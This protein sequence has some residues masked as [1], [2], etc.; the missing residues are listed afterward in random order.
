M[1]RIAFFEFL[2][3]QM[4]FFSR[5]F[6]YLDQ[7]LDRG[8]WRFHQESYALPTA[9]SQVPDMDHQ[10][11][12]LINDAEYGDKFYEYLVQ[13]A[14]IEH[15]LFWL[16]VSIFKYSPRIPKE[17]MRVY[18]ALVYIMQDAPLTISIAPE[19]RASIVLTL[20]GKLPIEPQMFDE[21]FFE[22]HWILKLHV[23]N[24]LKKHNLSEWTPKA[25]KFLL[26]F[27]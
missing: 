6:H 3:I 9:D 27:I 7:L 24:F 16:D 2:I 14:S 1:K 11:Y 15:L 19:T 25:R 17:T 20:D 8:L 22:V 18:L 23:Y 21:A 13:K 26:K 12:Q 4:V 10:L 5:L